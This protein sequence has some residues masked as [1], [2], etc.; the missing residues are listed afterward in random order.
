[1]L[2]EVQLLRAAA[3]VQDSILT[4]QL[5]LHRRRCPAG[6]RG[7]RRS[8]HYACD[9]EVS[10]I[11]TLEHLLIAGSSNKE[12]Y[13]RSCTIEFGQRQPVDE[14]VPLICGLR[15]LCV[16]TYGCGG[17]EVEAQKEHV[18]PKTRTEVLLVHLRGALQGDWP[19]TARLPG[20]LCL[21][22]RDKINSASA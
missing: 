5:H 1:M 21:I 22:K 15:K 8:N 10:G 20:L 7:L 16:L 17:W 18:Q 19:D 14:R 13:S 4:S 9:G 11:A 3:G 6:T 12:L 2:C